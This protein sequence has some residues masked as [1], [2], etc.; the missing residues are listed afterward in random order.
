MADADICVLGA[1]KVVDGVALWQGNI[2]IDNDNAENPN[3]PLG[4]SDVYQA[5]GL[6]SLP[7]P[8]DADGFAE[9]V[10]LRNVAGRDV[11]YVGAR[12]TRSAKIVGK[13]RPGDTVVHSTGPSQAAQLQLKEEKRQAVLYTKD[14]RG[15][16]VSVILDGKNNK[17]QIMGFGA[18][19]EI[20][21]DGDI[22]LINKAGKGLLIQSDGVHVRGKL[23]IPGL[24]PGMA[25]MQG[26]QTGSS[27][28]PTSAPMTACTGFGASL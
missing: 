13:M 25:V 4:E 8:K 10:A 23:K 27:G 26:P 7:Y 14:T 19:I 20:D 17:L 1:S 22:S 12:D 15:K 2:P 3:E 9:A 16:G 28:G 6:T 21:K 24:R 5:L 11:V 18:T